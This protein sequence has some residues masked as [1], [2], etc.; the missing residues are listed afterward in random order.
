MADIDF[1]N[2]KFL[3]KTVSYW[4]YEGHSKVDKIFWGI[5]VG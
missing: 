5:V 3:G 4:S 1:E 2:L